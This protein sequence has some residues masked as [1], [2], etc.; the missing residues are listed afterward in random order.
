MGLG[1]GLDMSELVCE[2]WSKGWSD[3]YKFGKHA[4]SFGNG[5]R[6]NT[7]KLILWGGHNFKRFEKVVKR[8]DRL[9]PH[10]SRTC[11]YIWEC[12]YLNKSI[13]GV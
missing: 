10:L 11:G 12:A 6:L 5:H 2:M 9:G 3:W 8:F 1:T 4:D 13:L 7:N